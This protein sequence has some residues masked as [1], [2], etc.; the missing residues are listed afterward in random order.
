MSSEPA[1]EIF[2]LR[3]EKKKKKKTTKLFTRTH[4]II[5]DPRPLCLPRCEPRDLQGSSPAV[6]DAGADFATKEP[7]RSRTRILR[8]GQG[9]LESRVK[10]QGMRV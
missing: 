5:L 3:G 1:C 10:G 4:P 8:R 2:S 6:H 7:Q 9:G